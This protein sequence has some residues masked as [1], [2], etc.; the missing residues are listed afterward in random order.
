M[1]AF[2]NLNPKASKPNPNS[3]TMQP[4]TWYTIVYQRKSQSWLESNCKATK[5]A[6]RAFEKQ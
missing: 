4:Q 3:K 2:L 5:E 6:C 1:V